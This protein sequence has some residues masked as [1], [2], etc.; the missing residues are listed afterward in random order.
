M[1][2]KEYTSSI[3]WL[4]SNHEPIRNIAIVILGILAFFLA[5]KRTNTLSGQHKTTEENNINETFRLASENLGREDNE[6][7]PILSVRVG[8]ILSLERLAI[9]NDE[10][11]HATLQL[12]SAYLNQNAK[13][14]ERSADSD[15]TTCFEVICSLL[16][17]GEKYKLNF[18][19]VELKNIYINDVITTWE[20]LKGLMLFDCVMHDVQFD[21]PIGM[22]KNCKII[23]S[24]LH[25]DL[26]DPVVVNSTF[27]KCKIIN[28]DINEMHANIKSESIKFVNCEVRNLEASKHICEGV[29]FENCKIINGNVLGEEIKQ[30]ESFSIN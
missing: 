24:K 20:N 26:Y 9:N 17:Y 8:A 6:Q 14:A 30:Q 28:L 21:S 12:L 16:N 7:N 5:W 19:H 22:I 3:A 2:G 13:Y 1:E 4:M 18:R 11:L 25:F 27:T 10:Y 15:C 29:S 23:K